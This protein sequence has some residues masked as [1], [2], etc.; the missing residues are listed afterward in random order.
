MIEKTVKRFRRIDVLVN[1][2]GG[3]WGIT[4]KDLLALAAARA[5]AA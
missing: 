4:R 3:S 5:S 1:C 2:V